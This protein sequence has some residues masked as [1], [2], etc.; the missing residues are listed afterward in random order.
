[1]IIALIVVSVLALALAGRSY[2]R[3]AD[4]RRTHTG[5]LSAR[6]EIKDLRERLERSERD[7]GVADA[8]FR[9]LFED[10]GA[11]IAIVSVDPDRAGRV[12]EANESL[13]EL[14]GYP[15]DQLCEMDISAISHPDDLAITANAAHRLVSGELESF[16]AEHRILTATGTVRW[17]SLS[18]SLVRDGDG[19]PIHRVVQLLDIS[20]RKRFEGQLQY[21]AD[22]DA[23]TGL[24]NRRR[25]EAELEREL[26]SSRRYDTGGALIVLDLDNFKY[27]NDSLGHAAGD[28]LISAVGHALSHRLRSSDTVGRLGGDEFAVILPHA[29]EEDAVLVARGIAEMVRDSVSIEAD[30]GPRRTTASI[31][32]A[33]FPAAADHLSAEE[34]LVEADIAMYDA[35]DGGRD[36]VALY[37]PESDRQRKMEVRLTWAERIRNALREDRFVL[38]AQPIVSLG[39]ESGAR[40]H[41]LLLRMIDESGDLIP[42]GTFLYVAERFGLV[43]EIDRWVIR[44]A[45]RMLAVEERSGRKACFAV[46]L[47]AKSIQNPAM[48]QFLAQRLAAT[49]VDPRGLMFEVTETVAIENIDRAK[50]FARELRDLGCSFALDDFGSG[51]ASFYYLKHLDFDYLKIDGEFIK[52][53]PSSETDQL[54]VRSLVDIAR[55][56]GRK[57]IAEFVGDDET[58]DILRDYGVDYAQGFHLGKPRP[59]DSA[60][61]KA[62][63]P[64]EPTET[65]EWGFDGP[66]GDRHAVSADEVPSSAGS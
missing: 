28:E 43:E 6:A 30:K 41:E 44:E 2:A 32:V 55:G 39:E 21:L 29:S 62:L 11:G 18:T 56:M 9:R 20:E 34:L 19:A 66:D 58:I 63:M 46:N 59:L 3:G 10:A 60:R 4:A 57:T 12:L 31:G 23:L 36:R 45:V 7:R 8:R 13:S 1:M 27:V 14:T 15:H 64:N 40:R 48:T 22:H 54:V 47:S 16:Q 50:Q 49:G 51:F 37:R 25:F 53:L 61:P 26:E 5:L 52:N 33:L 35:K 38:H 24:F 65:G 42:P 17:V